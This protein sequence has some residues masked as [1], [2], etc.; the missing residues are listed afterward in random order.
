MFTAMAGYYI[1]SHDSYTLIL[2]CEMR[3]ES[4]NDSQISFLHTSGNKKYE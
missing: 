3:S 1:S 4:T 2:R